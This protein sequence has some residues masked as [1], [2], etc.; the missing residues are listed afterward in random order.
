MSVLY[1]KITALT[2]MIAVPTVSFAEESKR[3]ISSENSFQQLSVSVGEHGNIFLEGAAVSVKQLKS[4][5]SQLANAEDYEIT[6]LAHEEADSQQVLEVMDVCCNHKVGK[7]KLLY[8]P[9]R[10]HKG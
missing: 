3:S 4:F 6:V 9:N 10:D 8:T 5:I 2:L 7:V 1:P